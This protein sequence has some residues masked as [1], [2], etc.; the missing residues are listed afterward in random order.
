MTC[1]A[2]R[3]VRLN[4]VNLKQ[5]AAKVVGKALQAVTVAKLEIM[6]TDGVLTEICHEQEKCG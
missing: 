1:Y 3:R 5:T 4:V 6:K 2:K